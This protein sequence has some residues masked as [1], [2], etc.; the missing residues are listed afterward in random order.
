MKV[1]DPNMRALNSGTLEAVRVFEWLSSRHFPF[2]TLD[3]ACALEVTD[4]SAR[5]HLVALDVAG[6]VKRI[7]DTPEP[8]SGNLQHTY[9]SNVRIRRADNG[10]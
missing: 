2:T 6:W 5:R 9:R 8:H 4:T 7:P 10:S 3:L 1:P